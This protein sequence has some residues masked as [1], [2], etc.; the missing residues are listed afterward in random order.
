M[1]LF[2]EW[3]LKKGRLIIDLLFSLRSLSNKKLD[4]L[5]SIDVLSDNYDDHCQEQLQDLLDRAPRLTSIR[6]SWK[7]LSSSLQQ[8]FESRHLSVYQ[9]EL[10]Y[11]GGTFDREQCMMLRKVISTIQC[12]VL[13]LVLEDRTFILDLIN[14]MPHLQAIN[15]QCRTGKRHPSSKITEKNS[16][17]LQQQLSSTDMHA[18][19]TQ[20]NDFIRLWI[21]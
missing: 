16:A 10:L 17:W 3:K 4:H 12:R 11:Y 18:I 7:T 15:V 5:I 13:N 1:V 19:I 14:T 20:Q 2:V 8:L 9:L 6:I 21:R